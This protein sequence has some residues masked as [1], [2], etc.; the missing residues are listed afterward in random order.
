MIPDDPP[1]ARAAGARGGR[2]EEVY[3]DVRG[4]RPGNAVVAGRWVRCAEEIGVW[5]LSSGAQGIA[6][7]GVTARRV[8]GIADCGL[9]IEKIRGSDGLVWRQ[10]CFVETLAC[11]TLH[12]LCGAGPH[13]VRRKN[14]DGVPL[15]GVGK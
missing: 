7:Q 15:R 14:T 10:A 11:V 12:S 6:T 8:G 4:M 3:R 13:G 2:T 9:R 5:S 1:G